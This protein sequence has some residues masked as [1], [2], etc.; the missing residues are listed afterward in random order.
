[1]KKVL[2]KRKSYECNCNEEGAITERELK[3]ITIFNESG[4]V[5]REEVINNG[6]VDILIENDYENDAL[7]KTTQTDYVNQIQQIWEFLY[8][9][10]GRK[11]EKREY[12]QDGDYTPTKYEYTTEGK[13]KMEAVLDD[14]GKIES[15]IDYEYDSVGNLINKVEYDTNDFSTPWISTSYQ[16]DINNKVV[17]KEEQFSDKDPTT[18]TFEYDEAGELIGGKIY[19]SE[20]EDLI[21]D[22]QVIEDEEGNVIGTEIFYPKENLRKQSLIKR[23]ENNKIIEEEELINGNFNSLTVFNYNDAN[24]IVEEKNLN[25]LGNGEFQQW[26]AK[27]YELE[28]F[29]HLTVKDEEE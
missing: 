12:F 23:N 10:F 9:E 14:D 28:Y 13:L 6:E 26:T 4:N 25:T 15:K 7:I 17:K 29:E 16:Y 2:K 18:S 8:D 24:D 22:Q 19:Y 27:A 3:N 20:D 21:V 1:M 5:I 11:I